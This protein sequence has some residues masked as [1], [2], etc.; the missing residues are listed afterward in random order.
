MPK[1]Q[2]IEK[3]TGQLREDIRNGVFYP[4]NVL[5][6]RRTLADK[7]ITTPDTITK[8]LKNLEVEGLIMKGKGRTMRVNMPRE[9]ITTNEETFRDYMKQQGRV[10]QVEHLASPDILPAPPDLARL[11]RVAP[12]T[13]L[14]E[15]ARREIVDGV[16]Y[17][18][19]KKYY[20]AE[21]VPS[22]VL[23]KIQQDYAY[24]V[25][26]IIEAQ[27][28]LIRIEERIIAR[29][30]VEKAEADIFQA[31][32]G[33]PVLEQ[34]KINYAENKEV[35]FISRVILNAFYFVKVYDYAPGNEPQSS[36]FLQEETKDRNR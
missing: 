30:I 16:V 21:L 33:L 20:R 27:K 19:S 11:F 17:R 32:T 10:V 15:R 24:S 13:P 25:K 31:A 29:A 26:K 22:D 5:P 7:F 36:E 23:E 1:S 3:I 4:Y 9:R 12:G 8:V 2:Q 35:T 18:Y 28:P 6:T 14:V 34:W